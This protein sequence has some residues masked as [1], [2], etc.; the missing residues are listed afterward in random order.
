[1]IT[2]ED[3]S[4][5]CYMQAC[6]AQVNFGAI[7]NASIRAVFG[8]NSAESYKASRIIKDS[9]EAQKIKALDANTAPR[10]MKY[11]PYWA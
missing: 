7:N 8:L 9:L 1:M 3:K 11:I 2:R 6:L 5:T 4:R 10:Y